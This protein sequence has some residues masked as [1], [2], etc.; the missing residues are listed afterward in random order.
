M[1]L[2]RILLIL[3][4]CMIGSIVLGGTLSKR[5]KHD[6][7]KCSKHKSRSSHSSSSSSSHSSSSSSK[8]SKSSKSSN[9]HHR[10]HHSTWKSKYHHRRPSE[11]FPSA[12]V[13][14]EIDYPQVEE[15]LDGD[16]PAAKNDIVCGQWTECIG[17]ELCVNENNTILG[18]SAIKPKQDAKLQRKL[19]KERKMESWKKHIDCLRN[20]VCIAKPSEG[21]VPCIDG[22]AFDRPCFNIDQASFI[23]LIDL[24]VTIPN[25]T[26]TE[27]TMVNDMWGWVDPLTYDEYILAGTVTHTSI[28]RVNNGRNPL[29]VANVPHNTAYKWPFFGIES[30]TWSDI[31][32]IGN[33]M[34][35]V[36]EARDHGLQY[37]DLTRVRGKK[38]FSYMEADGVL[39]VIGACHNLISNTETGYL[40]ATPSDNPINFDK[41]RSYYANCTGLH[42]IDANIPG[43]PKFVGCVNA[44]ENKDEL[45]NAGAHDAQ[46]V[47]YRGPDKRYYGR[48][49]CFSCDFDSFS[50]I[51]VTDHGLN[52][53]VI[54]RTTYDLAKYTHQA[55]SNVHLRPIRFGESSFK[56]DSRSL[57]GEYRPQQLREGELSLSSQ[58]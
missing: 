58:L 38:Q 14:Y 21:F 44:T 45:G 57:S 33:Y 6:H 46:C 20:N 18:K 4:V 9:H 15:V 48:E 56:K 54:T 27:N 10:Y 35:V 43:D 1:N 24:N 22:F 40:Y 12:S 47:I 37:F 16:F 50:I 34:Y 17:K 25:D 52:T 8:S 42:I 3:S 28:I 7:S 19:I 11:Y 39:N 29:L 53:K 31:K 2:T 26:V 23:S 30:G 13:D 36:S 5:S 32:T 41:K 49:L 51:D 55:C